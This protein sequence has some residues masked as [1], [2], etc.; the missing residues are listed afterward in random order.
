MIVFVLLDPPVL[1]YHLRLDF[2][3]IRFNRLYCSDDDFRFWKREGDLALVSMHEPGFL[4]K[5]KT[6]F[7]SLTFLKSSRNKKDLNDVT[8]APLSVFFLL[9]ALRS[10]LFCDNFTQLQLCRKLCT[11]LCFVLEL[12]VFKTKHLRSLVIQS[13]VRIWI[14]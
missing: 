6:C 9:L 12:S 3:S 5:L 8:A 10:F 1:T 2:F 13:F 4:K 11:R 14:E 7:W